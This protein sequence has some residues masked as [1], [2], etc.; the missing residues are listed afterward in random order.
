VSTLTRIRKVRVSFVWFERWG[1]VWSSVNPLLKEF[2]RT[3]DGY[4]KEFDDA[5]KETVIAPLNGQEIPDSRLEST[6]LTPP[7]PVKQQPNSKKYPHW[8]WMFYLGKAPQNVTGQ[9]ALSK[10][11][12]FHVGFS[13]KIKPQSKWI[14]L[15]ADGFV[16]PHGVGLVLT[17]VLK[18]DTGDFP[19]GGVQTGVA[20]RSILHACNDELYDVTW[21]GKQPVAQRLPELTDALLDDLHNRMLG[22][23]AKLGERS[24]LPFTTCGVVRGDTDLIATAP[25]ENGDVHRMLQG[26]SSLRKTWDKDKLAPM[27]DALLRVRRS[28]PEGDLL[29]HTSR[30]RT[31]WFPSSFTEQRS[32]IRSAGCYHRNLTLLNLQAEALLQALA[33]RSDLLKNKARV[34]P[35]L[36]QMA[37]DGAQQLSLLYGSTDETYQS[38]SVRA[39]LDETPSQKKLVDDALADFGM[40]KLKYI[41]R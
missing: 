31:V 18:L 7:W 9:L 14:S 26:T 36:E 34:P 41:P 30:G 28:A 16:Y 33:A 32:F 22:P 15:I 40:D 1:D 29:Y 13:A 4:Q 23:G 35:F 21:N 24:K 6:A 8:F 5:I 17:V 3:G 25:P 10:L 37:K 12:P 39:Y 20:M 2:L 11:A 27:K 19:S 38:S